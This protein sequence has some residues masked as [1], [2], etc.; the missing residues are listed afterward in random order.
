MRGPRERADD[1]RLEIIEEQD[2]FVPQSDEVFDRM[3]F[4]MRALDILRPRGMKVVLYEGVADIRVEQGRDL[5]RGAR[6]S[7]ATVGIPPHATREHIVYELAVL[8]G[9]ADRPWI[10]S[11]LLQTGRRS[12]YR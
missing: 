5:A 1:E 8:A 12:A 2:R 10:L 6:A 7:W 9:V 3:A 4:A 11:L